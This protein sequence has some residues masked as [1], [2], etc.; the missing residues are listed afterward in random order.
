MPADMGITEST[1]VQRTCFP[2]DTRPCPN[3]PATILINGKSLDLHEPLMQLTKSVCLTVVNI[4]DEA[5]GEKTNDVFTAERLLPCRPYAPPIPLYV[6]LASD[7]IM[8]SPLNLA[9]T[10]ERR[11]QKHVVHGKLLSLPWYLS[12]SSGRARDSPMH[13]TRTC[14]RRA[15]WTRL[16]APP[17]ELTDRHPLGRERRD[18]PSQPS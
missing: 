17:T 5:D 9:P 18:L 11:G 16:K 10:L 13:P 4:A 3:R 15:C 14:S 2:K 7:E 8:R 12:I 6:S 1:A